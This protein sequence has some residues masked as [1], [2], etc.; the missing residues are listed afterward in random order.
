MA[1]TGRHRFDRKLVAELLE[2]RQEDIG[3]EVAKARKSAGWLSRVLRSA[4]AVAGG[5]LSRALKATAPE[6]IKLEPVDLVLNVAVAEM[7]LL[8]RIL[9]K[10]A[11]AFNQALEKALTRHEK[12]WTKIEKAPDDPA[13]L[14]PLGLTA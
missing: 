8:Y 2:E 14:L 9:G 7:D 6:E 13:A 10:D 12:Y 3:D 4:R 1:A 5:L 11:A